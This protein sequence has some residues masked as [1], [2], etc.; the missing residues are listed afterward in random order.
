MFRMHAVKVCCYYLLL[1]F[2]NFIARVLEEE[3]EKAKKDL[4]ALKNENKRRDEMIARLQAEIDN[5]K[6]ASESGMRQLL[7]FTKTL[8][9]PSPYFFT[10]SLTNNRLSSSRYW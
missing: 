9:P 8:L 3:L 1:A 7:M 4:E 5:I 10:S 2:T 6:N